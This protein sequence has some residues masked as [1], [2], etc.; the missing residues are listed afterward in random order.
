MVFFATKK[1]LSLLLNWHNT[2]V[3][4]E[5]LFSKTKTN[6]LLCW[7]ACATEYLHL[8]WLTGEKQIHLSCPEMLQTIQSIQ[9]THCSLVKYF[10]INNK[11]ANQSIKRLK[12]NNRKK[13]NRTYEVGQ[14]RRKNIKKKTS[15]HNAIGAT[16]KWT[17][18]WKTIAKINQCVVQECPKHK[19]K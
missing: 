11:L 19:T 5:I 15:H 8:L 9:M 6:K 18:R 4:L 1:S 3:F 16:T 14:N 7:W 13:L 10:L 17:F 12:M 2:L